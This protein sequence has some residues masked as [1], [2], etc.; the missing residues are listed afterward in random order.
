LLEVAAEASA[1][2]AGPEENKANPRDWLAT[3]SDQDRTEVI[4][5]LLAGEGAGLS[6]TLLRRFRDWD[7][8]RRGKGRS[9]AEGPPRRRVVDL[10]A[11]GEARAEENRRCEAEKKARAAAAL[12]KRKAAKR[13]KYL[14]DL[15]PRQ[16][17][18][19]RQVETLIE[20][21]R[22]K[23]YDEAVQLLVDL[24]D[25]AERDGHGDEVARRIGELRGRHVKKP[26]LLKRLDQANL[27]R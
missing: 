27:P 1:D 5:Q 17:E 23:E 20:A 8:A 19:W 21:K 9:E 3:W 12:A 10:L 13:A 2:L 15:A 18:V 25:L 6:M 16:A 24:R 22:P 14:D 11:A 7:A 4:L 26:A